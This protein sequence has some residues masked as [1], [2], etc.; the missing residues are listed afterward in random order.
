MRADQRHRSL[1]A[2]MAVG[3]RHD[4]H[5][6]KVETGGRSRGADAR[7]RPDQD[8]HDQA[9]SRR[10]QRAF[11]ARGVAGMGD[12]GWHRW[13][14]A[15][16]FEQGRDHAAGMG[17]ERRRVAGL[18]Q[19]GRGRDL[20]G[21]IKHRSAV[22]MADGAAE[23][24]C[25]ARSRPGDF[26]SE[27]KHVAIDQAARIAEILTQ[28]SCAR[29]G[30]TRDQQTRHQGGCRPRGVGGIGRAKQRRDRRQLGRRHAVP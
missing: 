14:S 15:A 22:G 16:A 11:D 25:P 2:G 1:R 20:G 19:R 12:G 18:V 24:E 4:L 29:A 28:Q 27:V 30:K 23:G 21:A 9:M 10:K 13:Q 8:G 3:R 17:A 26:Y 6:G 7:L 5:A